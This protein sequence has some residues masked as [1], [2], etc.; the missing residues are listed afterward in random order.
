[1]FSIKLLQ[2]S[3]RSRVSI[4]SSQ[5]QDSDEQLC[6]RSQVNALHG[7]IMARCLL[8]HEKLDVQAGT[9]SGKFQPSVCSKIGKDRWQDFCN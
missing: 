3:C 9:V 4:V 5:K 8:P 1:M 2:F 6:L 7:I